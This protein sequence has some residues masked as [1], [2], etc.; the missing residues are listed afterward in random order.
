MQIIF[1][2][3]LSSPWYEYVRQGKKIYEGRRYTPFLSNINKGDY[4]LFS[5]YTDTTLPKIKVR[6]LDI[7]RFDT[8]EQALNTL[9]IKDILP[10]LNLSITEGVE[11][12]NIFNVYVSLNTQLKDGIV[13]IHIQKVL[14]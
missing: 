14:Y 4:I 13:M 2:M 12:Y 7:H 10:I 8:F 5:H 3:K 9:P 6:V 11:I 1:D